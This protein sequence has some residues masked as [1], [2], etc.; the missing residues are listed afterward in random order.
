MNLVADN[1]RRF[2]DNLVFN[3]ADTLNFDSDLIPHD[4]PLRGLHSHANTRWG[5]GDD[6][7]ARFKSEGGGEERYDFEAVENQ[8]AG[9]GILPWVTIDRGGQSQVVRVDTIAGDDDRTNWT[10]GITRFPHS[11]LRRRTA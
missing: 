10:M 1:V 2:L 7:I 6:D 3:V 4:E 8:V 5:T 11:E 9:V